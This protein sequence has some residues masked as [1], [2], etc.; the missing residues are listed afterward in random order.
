MRVVLVDAPDSFLAE[1][2]RLGHDHRDEMWEGEL[3]MVPQPSGHHQRMAH[4][5]GAVLLPLAKAAGLIGL[6]EPGV[7]RP[8][9]TDSWRVPELGYCRPEHY[10]RQKGVVG[11]TEL[12]VEIRSP[13]DETYAK[14]PY[15]ADLGCRDV[16]VIDRDSLAVELFVLDGDRLVPAAPDGAGRVWLASVNA[17][18]GRIE[19]PGLRV[20]WEGG[21]ADLVF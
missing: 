9:R 18:I 16:L 2:E 20:E 13:R 10:S 5:L 19:G 8:G 3:H 21:Q 15:Y 12:L 11:P 1:R 17:W 7:H 6:Q 4:E 14:L